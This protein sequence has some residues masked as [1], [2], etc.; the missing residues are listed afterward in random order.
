MMRFSI[1]LMWYWVHR[2]SGSWSY[3]TSQGWSTNT[4]VIYWLINSGILFLP[5]FKW[6]NHLV[7]K[8]QT[9]VLKEFPSLSIKII[10]IF[11]KHLNGKETLIM[12]YS[13]VRPMWS[14]GFLVGGFCLA[15]EFHQGGLFKKRLPRKKKITPNI[16]RIGVYFIPYAAL[17]VTSIRNHLGYKNTVHSAQL[18]W[19]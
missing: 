1:Y 18:C 15:V 8:V 17:I 7:L 19:T 4:F 12:F 13:K 16:L 6:L 10:L 2:E 14:G 11:F 5:I 3:A 9:S